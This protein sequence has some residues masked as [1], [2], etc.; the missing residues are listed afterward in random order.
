M[1]RQQLERI[2]RVLNCGGKGGT[3]GPCPIQT[4]YQQKQYQKIVDQSK[5]AKFSKRLVSVNLTDA[6]DSLETDATIKY[7]GKKY[8]AEVRTSS[9]YGNVGVPGGRL[10]GV[11]SH[12]KPEGIASGIQKI[13]TEIRT[14]KS[15]D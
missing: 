6:F 12:S 4:P 5:I 14:G 1:T 3:P 7:D 10:R 2:E 15:R 8:H 13:L 11:V 9:G